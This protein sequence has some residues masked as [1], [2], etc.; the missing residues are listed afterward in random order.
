[1]IFQMCKRAVKTSYAKAD[2]Q[3]IIDLP[4]YLIGNA[5]KQVCLALHRE[6]GMSA[7]KNTHRRLY[8]SV[9]TQ[10]RKGANA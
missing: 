6:V 8:A 10:G 3:V 4:A 1:M 5:E 9:P 7:G 2:R